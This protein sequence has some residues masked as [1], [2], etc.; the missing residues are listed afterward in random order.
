MDDVIL[1][2]YV[3][4]YNHEKYITRALDSILMQKTGYKYEILVGEDASTDNTREILK[5][6]EKKHPGRFKIFYREKNMHKR[7][8]RN[9]GDLIRR[10]HGKYIVALEGD[11]Y[12][13]DENKLEEQINFLENHPDY[14]AV[15]H[16]CI[17]VNSDSKPNGEEYPECRDEEYTINHFVSEI[18]PG[19]LTT[20]MKRNYRKYDIM[21]TSLIDEGLIPGDRIQY[22]SMLCNGKVHCIQKK[23]SAYRHVTDSGSSYSAGARYNYKNAERMIIE[24]ISYAKK[25]GNHKNMK[26]MEF[27]YL[28]NIRAGIKSAQCTKKEAF[29]DFLKLDNKLTAIILYMKFW[30]NCHIRHKR[31]WL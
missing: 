28:K 1:S 20:V 17:V 26:Y 22:F 13:I 10:C 31:I 3:P 8:I 14:I 19:Q 9:A 4:T 25:L 27:S 23:M 30:V 2:I 29:Y 15:A 11:D 12:W 24:C 6:Y 7:K 5:Q 16:N 18:M 21:D